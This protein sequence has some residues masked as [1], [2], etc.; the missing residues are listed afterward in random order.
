VAMTLRGLVV[1]A[2]CAAGAGGCSSYW[3]PEKLLTHTQPTAV[4]PA[5][6]AF[7]PY[8]RVNYDQNVDIT[9]KFCA[10]SGANAWALNCS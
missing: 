10:P 4:R 5:Q 1:L 9:R 8:G 7:D 2:A 3:P 6:P